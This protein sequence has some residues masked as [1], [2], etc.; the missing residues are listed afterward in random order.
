LCDRRQVLG[1]TGIVLPGVRRLFVTRE[2]RAIIIGAGPAGLA[3]AIALRKAGLDTVVY[4]RATNLGKGTGLTLWPNGLAALA[5]LGAGE[6]VRARA[7]TA[8]GM[9]IRSGAGRV[10]NEVSGPVMDRIGGRGVA[11]QRAELLEALVGIFGRD[12]VRF[13]ARCVGVRSERDRAIVRFD[14]GVEV[15]ADVVVGADGIRSRVRSACGLDVPLKYGGFAVWR[16]TIPFTLPPCPGSLSLGGPSQF[17]IWRLPG[18]RVYWFASTPAIEG[19]QVRRGSRPPVSFS[20]WHDPIPALLAATPTEQIMVTDIYD[21]VPLRAWYRG[22]VV[23]VG[24]AAHPS[25]PNMGQGTSQAFEDAAVLAACLRAGLDVQSALRGYES[26]RHRRAR[27]AW[28]QARMLAR[29]GAWR[30]PPACWL[31]EKMMVAVPER[32]Q[33]RQLERLFTF[34]AS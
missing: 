30:S 33:Q 12:A 18:D 13:G 17:G 20:E 3:A 10:L 23:L 27:A 15:S 25:M 34:V 9:L 24:D 7:L 19:T 32:A 6:G 28:S 26:R 14:D 31:R 21:S 4:E 2:P 1:V 11:L 8:P 16:A 29:V 22:R 5:T